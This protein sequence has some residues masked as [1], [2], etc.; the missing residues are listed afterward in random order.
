MALRKTTA[1]IRGSLLDKVEERLQD[2]GVKGLSV[3]HIKG[4]GEH[5]NFFT[6]NLAGQARQNRDFRREKP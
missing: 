2:L 3:S 1:I 6:H 4:Y 5:A